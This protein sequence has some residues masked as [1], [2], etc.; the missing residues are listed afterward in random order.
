MLT[1]WC[2]LLTRD[3]RGGRRS[4]LK[5]LKKLG[6]PIFFRRAER[7]QRPRALAAARKLLEAVRGDLTAWPTS[8]SWLNATHLA[9][10]L[11]QVLFRLLLVCVSHACVCA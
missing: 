4:K 7:L 3:R 8:R 11:E 1:R 10:A 2:A 9:S 5:D 6:D